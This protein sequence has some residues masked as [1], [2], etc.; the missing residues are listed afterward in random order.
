MVNVRNV[1]YDE[2]PLQQ[3]VSQETTIWATHEGR[4]TVL[5]HLNFFNKVISELLA[6]DV[7]I[8]EKDKTLILL[9]SLSES[10]GYIVTTMLYGKETLILEEVTSTL[11]SNEIR[12]GQIKRRRH[13]RI[14]WLR[15]GKE[16]EKERKV[17]ARQRRVTFVTEKVIGRMTASIDKSG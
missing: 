14:W 3:A 11:L 2:K 8:D 16:E 5:E 10:Y 12:K 4:T 15:E 9:T 1:V 17:Q 13:D 7:N 6:V